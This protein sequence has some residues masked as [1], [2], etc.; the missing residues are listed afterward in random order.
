MGGHTPDLVV[1]ALAVQPQPAESRRL[2][3][4]HITAARGAAPDLVISAPLV[5]S[6]RTESTIEWLDL[7]RE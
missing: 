2:C 7:M 1:S 3:P 5:A 6:P 4:A